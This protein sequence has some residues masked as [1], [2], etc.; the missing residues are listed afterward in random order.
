MGGR[1]SSRSESQTR[2][3]KLEVTNSRSQT[4]GHKLD[5][6]NSRLQCLGLESGATKD[7]RQKGCEAEN[8]SCGHRK[9]GGVFFPVMSR[10]I[11]DKVILAKPSPGKKSEL[12]FIPPI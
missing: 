1:G 8:S 5:V 10:D 12:V 11:R 6:T 3:H 9:N 4:R 7:S 2:G